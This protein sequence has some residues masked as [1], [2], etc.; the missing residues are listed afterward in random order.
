MT[1]GRSPTT[2]LPATCSPVGTESRSSSSSSRHGGAGRD[3]PASRTS[4]GSPGSPFG[5]LASLTLL[6]L[7]PVILVSACAGGDG[8]DESGGDPGG[9]ATDSSTGSAPRVVASGLEVPWEIRFLPGGDLLVTERPGRLVRLTPGGEVL[10][11][12]PVPGVVARSE[13]G[14]MGLALHPEFRENRRLYLCFTTDSGDGLANRVERFEY[15]EEGLSS[16]APMVTGMRGAPFHD[17]CRL[18]FGP[19]GFLYV[20]MGDAGRETDAQ[21]TASLNGKIL[22]VDENGNPAPGNPFEN[23][24][25]TYGHRNPQGLAFDGSGRL[26]S[27][28]HGPS[29]LSSGYDE[30]NLV[31]RGNNYGWPEIRGDETASG[32]V[33]PAVHS[34][35]SETWAPAGAAWHDGALFFGGLRGEALYRVEISPRSLSP[36]A[37]RAAELEVIPHFEGELGRIR[38]VRRGPDGVLYF[39]TSNRDGRGNVREGDDRILAVDPAVFR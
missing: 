14:L 9:T 34:G 22:R 13:S 7:M 16:G 39:S 8:G 33:G 1:A 24:V 31:I 21:D 4:L 26:W 36:T 27:T 6:V 11:S 29:G 10:R 38:A 19:D 5:H 37:Q 18:E 2:S 28:E 12:D 25:Y 30:V 35:S 23:E 32:M 20:T 3:V 15:G 17:G